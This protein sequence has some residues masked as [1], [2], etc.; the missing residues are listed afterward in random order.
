MSDDKYLCDSCNKEIAEG[1]GWWQ[2]SA[3]GERFI[4]DYCG[5][6]VFFDDDGQEFDDPMTYSE[7]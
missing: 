5:D 6:L 7:E 4:C 2:T 3:T 1:N